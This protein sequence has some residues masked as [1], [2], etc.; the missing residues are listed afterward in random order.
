MSCWRSSYKVNVAQW[1]LYLNKLRQTIFCTEKGLT[2]IS[3]AIPI[4]A[5]GPV[6]YESPWEWANFDPRGSETPER[7]SM[8]RGIYNYV[9]GI[10]THANP[11]GAATTWVVSANTWLVTSLGFLVHLFCFILGIAPS[12]HCWTDFDDLYV[13]WRLDAQE[14]AFWVRDDITP[15]LGI[16]SRPQKNFENFLGGVNR[17]F[18]VAKE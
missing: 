13:I 16:Y 9:G 14:S 3:R 18:Q 15:H 6:I 5:K 8:K 4:S 7:I 17:R 12:P 11:Y 1:M 10:T 2:F